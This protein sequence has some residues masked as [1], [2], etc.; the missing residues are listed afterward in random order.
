MMMRIGLL[1]ASL[2]SVQGHGAMVT[3]VPH[4]DTLL[5]LHTCFFLTLCLVVPPGAGRVRATPWTGRS[6]ST[7]SA[8]RTSLRV[9]T[10]SVRTAKRPSGTRKGEGSPLT[11]RFVART[12][13][14]DWL[15]WLQV[16]HRLPDMRQRKRAPPD[17]PVRPGKEADADRCQVL[18]GESRRS[19]VQ[20]RRYLP[21]ASL[22]GTLPS[23]DLTVC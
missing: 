17:R 10:A 18:V 20:R 5:P 19:P 22:A 12:R 14:E 2:V 3:S 23:A 15:A 6:M 13:A 4:L 8:V 9:R 7:H 21:G 11:S 1:L 16:L